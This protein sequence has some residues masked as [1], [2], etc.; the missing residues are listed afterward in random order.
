MSD[1]LNTGR[2]REVLREEM[3]QRDAI[4]RLLRSGPMT[5]P[6]LALAMSRPAADVLL[7]VMAMRRY[8]Y[9]EEKGRPDAQG[10]FAYAVKAREKT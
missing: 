3:L 1:A 10:Y 4:L 8:G 9:V 2:R 6:A 5:I 7:W